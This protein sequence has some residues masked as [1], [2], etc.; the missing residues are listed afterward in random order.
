M[1]GFKKWPA[2]IF[3]VRERNTVDT[4]VERSAIFADLRDKLLEFF[5]LCN[6][7]GKYLVPWSSS[8]RSSTVPS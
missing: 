6:V 3:F 1:A 7:A 5:R 4:N 8:P 2:E